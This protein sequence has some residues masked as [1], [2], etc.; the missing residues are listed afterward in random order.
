MRQ[1]PVYHD[2]NV[3]YWLWMGRGWRHSVEPYFNTIVSKDNPCILV[4]PDD[5]A[6][7]DQYESTSYAYSMAFYHSPEQINT[8]TRASDT[9][10]H[11]LPGMGQRECDVAEPSH[12]LLIGEWTSNHNQVENDGGWWCWAGQRMFI[13]ADGSIGFLEASS[14]RKARDGFPDVNLTQ[15]GIKGIDR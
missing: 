1:D 3:T 15:D 13:F 5:P 11:P 14:I 9:Y 12:K 7:P 10:S 2:P 6:N 4:C 8:M